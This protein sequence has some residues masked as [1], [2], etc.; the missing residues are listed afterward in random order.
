MSSSP[1]GVLRREVARHQKIQHTACIDLLR[2]LSHVRDDQAGFEIRGLVKDKV[3]DAST[4]HALEDLP[5]VCQVLHYEPSPGAH[6]FRV[7]T[8][9][10]LRWAYAA[11]IGEDWR[12]DDGQR[13]VVDADE[14][15]LRR[16][17]GM[18]YEGEVDNPAVEMFTKYVPHIVDMCA[19]FYT[20]RCFARDGVRDDVVEM[21]FDVIEPRLVEDAFAYLEA[22]DMVYYEMACVNEDANLE[23]K[24]RES[25][26]EMALE[27]LPG[28]EDLLRAQRG[29]YENRGSQNSVSSSCLTPMATHSSRFV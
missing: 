23:S 17:S 12:R 16:D 8:D 9:V 10:R 19:P 26:V 28:P 15:L 13:H 22:D 5:L 14:V 20:R 2:R 25:R 4:V 29:E 7:I 21:M 6:S 1:S 24:R 3:Y 11:D 27:I 18:F